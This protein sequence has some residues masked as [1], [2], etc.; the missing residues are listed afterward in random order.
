MQTQLA[1][2]N[3]KRNFNYLLGREVE[4][5]F[6][7]DKNVDFLD[8]L[9][10]DDLRQS[11]NER[12]SSLNKQIKDKSIS[13][14]DYEIINSAFYPRIA[15]K[16]GYSFSKQENDAGMVLMNQSTGFNFGLNASY[17]LFD[18]NKTSIQSQNAKVNMLINDIKY[19]D[20]KKQID[21]NLVNN[22]DIY[23]RRKDILRLEE[24]NLKTSEANFER[25]KELFELGQITAIEFRD[26]QIN[27]MNSRNRINEAKYSAKIAETEL[28]L[29]SGSYLK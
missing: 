14:L 29:L 17:N 12:N 16:T 7:F 2:E 21:L 10:V 1:L 8:L 18:G 28:L 4:T 27:L 15:F 5:K 6:E 13:E 23:L 3:L 24:D 20:I 26:A 19:E 25:S 11:A 22:Y 9:S